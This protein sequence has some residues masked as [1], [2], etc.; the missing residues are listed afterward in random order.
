VLSRSL[1]GPTSPS[2]LS[3]ADTRV[4]LAVAIFALDPDKHRARFPLSVLRA[5]GLSAA[6]RRLE[7]NGDLVGCLLPLDRKHLSPL[8]RDLAAVIEDSSRREGPHYAASKG[9]AAAKFAE[10][11]GHRKHPVDDNVL[12]LGDPVISK[13]ALL[14]YC[15]QRD[16]LTR[17]SIHSLFSRHGSRVTL[18][19]RRARGAVDIVPRE[20]KDGMD[21]MPA[22]PASPVSYFSS[23]T[24][25]SGHDRQGACLFGRP[26][27]SPA[28]KG[29]VSAPKQGSHA[30]SSS[31]THAE[32]PL[33]VLSPSDFARLYLALLHCA[34]DAGVR[35]WFRVLDVDGDDRVGLH[36][37][38]HFYDERR[39]DA[40]RS[41]GV[42]LCDARTVWGR[43]CSAALGSGAAG[44]VSGAGGR[45]HDG[46]LSVRA[47]LALP[48]AEREY[49]LSALLIRR[50]DDGQLVD[51]SATERRLVR[52]QQELLSGVGAMDVV[53]A[54]ASSGTAAVAAPPTPRAVATG[55]MPGSGSEM[56]AHDV[57]GPTMVLDDLLA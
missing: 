26:T 50:A 13:G 45:L 7:H 48:K 27:A 10:A 51:Q 2:A 20:E 28:T 47:V 44:S 30:C 18:S 4:A 22:S 6:L 49:L 52:Q 1:F 3:G 19:A 46:R 34:S 41:A 38:V 8:L 14:R 5:V 32:K 12:D 21:H 43:V 40:E 15:R 24:D 29:V 16:L 39:R 25:R 31:A 9:S 17:R 53:E 57:D 56:D 42:V 36:D 55:P 33:E 37:A 54:A 11:D 35:Y 23:S